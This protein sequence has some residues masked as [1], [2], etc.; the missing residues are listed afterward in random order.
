[1]IGIAGNYS[2]NYKAITLALSTF[3]LYILGPARELE[4]LKEPFSY[5]SKS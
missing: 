5:H 3:E 1:M 4:E 2:E